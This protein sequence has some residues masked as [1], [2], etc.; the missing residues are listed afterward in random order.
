VGYHLGKVYEKL[1][2][3]SCTEL[4]RLL[5]DAGGTRAQVRSGETAPLAGRA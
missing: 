1:G 2:V 3:R 5:A 4:A